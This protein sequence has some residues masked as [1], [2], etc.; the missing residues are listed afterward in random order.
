MTKRI[1][2]RI[3][4]VLTSLF[5][6]GLVFSGCFGERVPE[7]DKTEAGLRPAPGSLVSEAACSKRVLQRLPISDRSGSLLVVSRITPDGSVERYHPYGSLAVPLLGYLDEYGRGLDGIEYAYDKFLL[8]SEDTIKSGQITPLSLTIDR[9][10][11]A[12]SEQNLRWQMKRLKAAK[13]SQIIMD[14]ASGHVIAMASLSAGSKG[15]ITGNLTE[16]FALED[17]I[18]PWALAVNLAWLNKQQEE[19]LESRQQEDGT[20][21]SEPTAAVDKGGPASWHWLTIDE[22]AKLWTRLSEDNIDQL[23][24]DNALLRQLIALGLGQPTGIDLPGERQGALPISLSDNVTSVISSGMNASPIQLLNAF[25]AIIKGGRLPRPVISAQHS[26]TQPEKNQP[27]E[28]QD[29]PLDEEALKQFIRTIGDN[30]GPSIASVTKKTDKN[31]PSYEIL[32]MGFWPAKS[33]KIG[34]ITV[35]G[36]AKVDASRRRGT[37]GR[38][39]LIAREA[40]S[41]SSSLMFAGRGSEN[42]A[43]SYNLQGHY[44]GQPEPWIM[45][46]LRG[47]S[48]RSAVEALD[49]LGLL[50][51]IKGAGTVKSQYPR[52]GSRI[53]RG[54]ECVITCKG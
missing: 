8:S 3:L 36:D 43:V 20:E 46:D 35:L 26:Q 29:I 41:L 38:T 54:I 1:F 15:K 25:S 21:T 39:A 30:H 31:Q 42:T 28:K 50:I 37:L 16:N 12:Q 19:L 11:Q 51:R 10:I 48:L 18:D 5:F 53:K 2:I 49:G 52:P 22:R 47:R 9:K 7:G 45:P 13:G 24:F 40:A 4:Y 14:L 6:C 17:G 23:S 32:G 33:P 27:G 44:H 34:Y